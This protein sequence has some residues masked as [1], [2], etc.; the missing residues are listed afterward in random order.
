MPGMR[1]GDSS[2]YHSG[3][4]RLQQLANYVSRAEYNPKRPVIS[5][6]AAAVPSLG[7]GASAVVAVTLKAGMG[8]TD[9][10]AVAWLTGS[11]QLLGALE[12]VGLPA[13]DT[14]SVVKVTVKNSGLLTLAGATV[15]VLALNG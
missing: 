15:L 10:Q 2:H 8:V 3:Y 11:Q 14:A 12:I 9:Y 1:R 7:I 4:V 6:G 5:A 13:V